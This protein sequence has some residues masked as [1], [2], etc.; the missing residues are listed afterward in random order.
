[1]T[2]SAE[3]I[4]R[5]PQ[6]RASSRVSGLMLT[7]KSP[8]RER[9]ARAAAR[10]FLR[11]SYACHELVIVNHGTYQV[12]DDGLLDMASEAGVRVSETR[13]SKL[14]MG[15]MRQAAL[16][17]ATGDICIQW[18]DDDISLP[19]RV[20]SQVAPILARTVD[21]TFLR[22]ILN[23]SAITNS[24]RVGTNRRPETGIDGTIAFRRMPGCNYKDLPERREDCD[25]R[26]N[27][28]AFTTV[29][30]AHLYIRVIHGDNIMPASLVM[31]NLHGKR[32]QWELSDD[33]KDVLR[34]AVT[35][36]HPWWAS[37]VTHGR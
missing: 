12:V 36:Y 29:E 15:K 35:I 2:Q 16:D 5:S 3:V 10:C 21:A 7:G 22:T 19:N 34:S 17:R 28:P 4:G 14:S 11:Q 23:W 24:A 37:L 9:L 31:K 26:G 1:M 6:A 20:E 32:N 27:F 30:G 33:L 13:I 18:D 8:Q 25:F